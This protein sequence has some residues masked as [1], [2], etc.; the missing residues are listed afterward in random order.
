M[1]HQICLRWDLNPGPPVYQS[2][3]ASL[4]QKGSHMMNCYNTEVRTQCV[5]RNQDSVRHPNPPLVQQELFIHSSIYLGPQGPG[6]GDT[7]EGA[8]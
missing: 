2:L 1:F 5:C 8:F 7:A 3:A 4:S 6:R